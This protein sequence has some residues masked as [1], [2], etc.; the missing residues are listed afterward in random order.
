MAT[1]NSTILWIIIIIIIICA[2][3]YFMYMS[4]QQTPYAYS[5]TEGLATDPLSQLFQNVPANLNGGSLLNNNFSNMNANNFLRNISSQANNGHYNELGQ[6]LGQVLDNQYGAGTGQRLGQAL[7]GQF[8]VGTG[9]VVDPTQ[10]T[11]HGMMTSGMNPDL[12][13]SA[14]FGSNQIM[15]PMVGNNGYLRPTEDVISLTGDT[16]LPYQDAFKN[17]SDS[18]YAQACG[19]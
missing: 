19:Q 9:Q 13:Q 18:Y 8:G 6:R 14:P 16:Y 4:Q 7:E 2:C 15:N 1:S 3:F 5:R 11:L 10:D 17:F 12:M